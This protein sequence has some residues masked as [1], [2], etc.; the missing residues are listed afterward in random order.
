MIFCIFYFI[1]LFSYLYHFEES[2]S[3]FFL[4]YTLYM[5]YIKILLFINYIY[6]YTYFFIP[7]LSFSNGNLVI[8]S[9]ANLCFSASNSSNNVHGILEAYG[10][11][12]RFRGGVGGFISSWL[13]LSFNSN[14]LKK[15]EELELSVRSANCLKTII[16]FILVI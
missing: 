11:T 1:F 9:S 8:F 13:A 12:F 4:H 10:C 2:N 14:L 16:L 7:G 5:I 6:I 3:S 15:V